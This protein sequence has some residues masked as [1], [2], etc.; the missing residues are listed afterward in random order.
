MRH[1]AEGPLVRATDN[2]LRGGASCVVWSFR[3]R[4]LE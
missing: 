2:Y 1:P 3:L 4:Y